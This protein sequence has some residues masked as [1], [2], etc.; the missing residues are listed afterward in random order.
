[1]TAGVREEL[2][3]VPGALPGPRWARL[4][5][6]LT[7]VAL[8]GGVGYRIALLAFDAPPTNSDE[9]TMGL[10]AL[11]IARGQDFP[12]WFYGQSYMGTLEAYLAAPVLAVTGPSLFGLRLVTVALYALFV[13]L[14]WRLTLRLTGDR[15]FALLLVVLLAFGSDRIVKNQLIA[16]GG[17]PEMNPAGVALAL[18]TYGLCT[19]RPGRR[20]P[21]WAAWGLLAGLMLWVDP[22]VLPYVVGPGAVLLAFRWRELRGRAGTVLGVAVL[23]GAAPLLGHSLVSGRNPLAAVLAAASGGAGVPAGWADRLHGGLLLGPPLGMGFCAPGNCATWQ[24]WWAFALPVLLV[25]GAVTAWRA[26]GVTRADRAPGGAAN[27]AGSARRADA[28]GGSDLKSGTTTNRPRSTEGGATEGRVGA[29]IR[30][31]LL[32]AGVA[33]LAA[34][35]LSSS[36]GRTPVESSRYL[37]CLL[38]SLPALLWPLWRA[39]RNLVDGSGLAG[40]RVMT[41]GPELSAGR[42]RVDGT[43]RRP[44]SGR[45]VGGV[46]G[47]VVFVATL[48]S[49]GY[50]TYRAIGTAPAARAAEARHAELVTALRDLGVRHVYGGYWTCNRLTFAS[51][52]DVVCAVVDDELRPG[53]D[54]YAPYRRAVAAS[55]APAWV[56]PTGSP[57]AARL[58]ERMRLEPGTLG[59]VTID[60]YRI[61]L[62]HA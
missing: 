59:L 35:T 51:G 18:L 32:A 9:A 10:A 25:V 62:A 19:G 54:R 43:G 8:L 3:D 5:G 27:R 38:I 26:L 30:L 52:E 6:V 16:G 61:Y 44:L 60:G 49:S 53:F 50:A 11:H 22:L 37:S 15:W 23:V 58:D 56:A 33:T 7:A 46:L 2:R 20:L 4:A 40:R 34:Y 41:A 57:L 13:L 36:A 28:A 55:A 12:V 48:G 14:A 31:A 1:M 39:A 29:A 42:N 24:L 47:V 45:R 17:Y 21:R